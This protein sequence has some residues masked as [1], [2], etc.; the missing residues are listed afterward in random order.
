[1]EI[2]SVVTLKSGGPDM[3][4]TS[5]SVV[6]V[7]CMWFMCTDEDSWGELAT[8]TFPLAAVSEAYA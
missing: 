3:T 1:V 7:G 2:G 4:V 5:V 6:D 8:G